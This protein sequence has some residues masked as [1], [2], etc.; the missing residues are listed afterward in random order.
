MTCNPSRVAHYSNSLIK[1]SLPHRWP[2][3][4]RAGN[5]VCFSVVAIAYFVFSATYVI[6]AVGFVELLRRRKYGK[7]WLVRW[8]SLK[9]MDGP[10]VVECRFKCGYVCH[11]K[12]A[13][14]V[15]VSKKHQQLREDS[16][17]RV[18]CR[19]KCGWSGKTKAAEN[20]HA[21][22]K[23]RG[24][25][26]SKKHHNSCCM[27]ENCNASVNGSC[28]LTQPNPPICLNRIMEDLERIPW[29]SRLF[30]FARWSRRE[31]VLVSSLRSNHPCVLA[32]S[33]DYS[34]NYWAIWSV[35]I[36]R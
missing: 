4:F 22:A 29:K 30:V 31:S 14:Y 17:T 24:Q 25:E 3:S 11:T 23:H 18:E 9:R 26:L 33:T 8:G 34:D 19:Y 21:S 15:H 2:Q 32:A 16:Q 7:V 6:R 1:L 20:N 12:N 35:G 13:E 27:E 10:A 28:Y 5:S 36:A